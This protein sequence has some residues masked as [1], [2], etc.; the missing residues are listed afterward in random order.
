MWMNCYNLYPK[1]DVYSKLF[2]GSENE[3]NDRIMH[4]V[5]FKGRLSVN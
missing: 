3:E 1:E 2:L 5:L 4:I